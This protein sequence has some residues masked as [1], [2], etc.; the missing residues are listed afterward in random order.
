MQSQRRR[1]ARP[2]A[3]AELM[4]I[5]DLQVAAASGPRTPTTRARAGGFVHTFPPRLRASNESNQGNHRIAAVG[6]ARSG[7]GSQQARA[8]A[9][10]RTPHQQ[11][12]WRARSG[13]RRRARALDWP[14]LDPAS[15]VAR[16]ALLLLT[17]PAALARSLRGRGRSSRG[18]ICDVRRVR[19]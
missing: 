12:S 15:V 1:L 9:R 13:G 7:S 18:K 4:T 3:A 17:R 8:Y 19:N 2:G 16:L 6:M 5:Q 11:A 14:R 10:S